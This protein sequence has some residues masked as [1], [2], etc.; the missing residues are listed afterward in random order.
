VNYG[1][2]ELRRYRTHPGRRD[3]LATL[4]EREYIDS[5][6]ECGMMPIGQYRDLDDPDAFVWLRGFADM[7]TRLRA[8]TAFYRESQVWRDTRDAANATMID[9]DNV[10]LLRPARP[11]SGLDLTGLE[12]PAHD[13]P[14]P[15]GYVAALILWLREPASDGVV[16]AFESS[17]LPALSA[18]GQRMATFVS[19]AEPNDFPA[20]P[21]REEPALVAVG[22]C[23]TAGDLAAWQDAANS[24]L[25]GVLQEHVGAAETLRLKPYQ[26]SLYR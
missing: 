22:T 16:A 23:A 12:R 13:G 8:L 15:P 19:A 17:L 10:L 18:R 11:N 24:A 7:A 4:F 5:Q 1:I 3:E 2:V 6:I 26:R 20:L 9:S 14:D 21:V 25:P